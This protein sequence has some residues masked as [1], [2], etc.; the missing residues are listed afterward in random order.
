MPSMALSEAI[1]LSIGTS[2]DGGVFS[3]VIPR[4]SRIPVNLSREYVTAFNDQKAINFKVL[5]SINRFY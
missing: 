4:N 5:F 2:T 3:K 1:P